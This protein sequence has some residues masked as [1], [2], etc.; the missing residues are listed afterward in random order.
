MC[1]ANDQAIRAVLGKH[2]DNKLHMIYCESKT[3]S[4]AQLNYAT[5]KK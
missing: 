2:K 1:D 3:L 4:D 5:M